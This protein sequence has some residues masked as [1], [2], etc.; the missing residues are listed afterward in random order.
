MRWLR[1]QL[2]RSDVFVVLFAVVLICVCAVVLVRYP[3]VHQAS[4]FGP[5]WD[6]K[7]VPNSEPVC[8]KKTSH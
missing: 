8:I 7:S 1:W 5:D 2:A 4:G 6:C 3:S